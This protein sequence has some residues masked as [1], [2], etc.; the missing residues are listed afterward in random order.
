M[1]DYEKLGAF[2]LGKA[3]DPETRTRKEELCLYDAKD[4]VTH[5]VCVGM[6]G[7]GKTGL[8]LG[9]IEEAAIDGI[10]TIAIDPKGD[11]GNLLLTFPELRPADF[12]PWVHPEDA[13]R[14]GQSVPEYAAKQAELWK[15]GL[16]AWQQ[17]GERIARFRSA[18]E[19]AIYTPGSRTGIPVSILKSFAAPA[20]D[21]LEDA[22]LLRTRIS[23][24][25]TSLLSLLGVEGDPLTSREHA[26]LSTIFESA[27][28]NAQDLDLT[29]VLSHIQSP[30]FSRVGVMDIETFY[31]AK[32][33]FALALRLNNLLASPGFAAWM[34]G[35]ALDIG[36]LYRT[37]AGKPRIA[38]FN[39]AHL[40]DPER[41]F[42]SALLLGEVLAWT[43]TQSG[44][45][46]LRAL[47]YMD[48]I[49]GYCPPVANPPSKLPL[50]T[51]MKQ[52]RAFGV[53]V[54]LAT[55]HPVDLDYKGLSNA[56][57][58]FIG[59]LQTERDKARVLDGLEG[60]AGQ[61]FDRATIDKLLSGLSSRVF[62][63]QNVH[64]EVP[65]VFE[66]RWCLSYLRGPLTRDQV[67][68]LMND[69]RAVALGGKPASSA[70]K[71]EGAGPAAPMSGG[72]FDAPTPV[73]HSPAPLGPSE[74]TKTRPV[75][76]PGITELFLPTPSGST[77]YVPHL[78]A[79]AIV[80]FRHQKAG[81]SLDSKLT[82]LVP[83]GS[84]LA[85]LD[86][87]DASELGCDERQLRKEPVA[88]HGF[89]A[90]PKPAL[91][92]K[93]YESWKRD[94]A[95]TL[96]RTTV[97]TLMK[98]ASGG[99][100]SE[101]GETEG[102]FRTRLQTK[103]HEQRDVEVEKLR[104]KLAPKVATLKERYRRAEQAVEVQA[105]QAK[106]ARNSS[107]I[108]IGSAV[109]GGLLGK[110]AMTAG[111]VGK[112]GTAIRGLGRSSRESSDVER[113]E[114]NLSAVKE[115]MAALEGEFAAAVLAIA[116]RTDPST[117][118]FETLELRPTK[119]NIRVQGLALA[120]VPTT[121]NRT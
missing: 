107:I 105:T 63:L 1:T 37:P 4:L 60:A 47:L 96:A 51:L 33:R 36:R 3:Y 116:Q 118:I 56:G 43:R 91:E 42:F 19:I 44:T 26:L 120:W 115:A 112:A 49:A 53:G 29:T 8:C 121:L 48:E 99:I 2:Y 69:R 104:Q 64:D 88:G 55:Q 70:P 31:P 38:I 13:A 24:T 59:R 62:Y 73:P 17:S 94:Y 95:E 23:T 5:A 103:A 15:N 34:E 119:T 102:D 109:L 89:T 83:F 84:G 9:L 86:W 68:T 85:T 41:M 113:A 97:L 106:E 25:A 90:P 100:V 67:K 58:W 40:S 82:H 11:L 45:T 81:I 72:L 27:W 74:S 14:K 7:S 111:N 12:E 21:L 6:T 117:E 75:L 52:A 71:G 46:S 28:R 50:L 16:A 10:P 98:S 110:K 54:V 87:D 80:S 108:S 92:P 20:P 32:D 22:D 76:P 66:T 61:G 35:E 30:P 39:L 114:D 79:Q 57:T 101:P 18:V 65:T 77:T 93:S 78:L